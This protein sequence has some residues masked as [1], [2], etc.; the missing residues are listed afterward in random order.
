MNDALPKSKTA[1]VR[2]ERARRSHR[3]ESFWQIVLPLLLGVGLIVYLVYQLLSTQASSS[4]QAAQV[5]V[6]LLA[7]PLLVLGI[8]L[9]A[10]LVMLMIGVS[11]L[12]EW[13]PQLTVRILDLVETM[14]A[15][16]HRSAHWAARPFLAIESWTA[17]LGR[18]FKRG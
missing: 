13:L 4:E 2:T 1:L 17:A 8:A 10:V 6:I 14:N 9:L 3:K 15:G 16:A 7:L 5:A 18:L 11:K 12:S